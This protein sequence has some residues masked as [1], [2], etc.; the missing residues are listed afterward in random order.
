MLDLS[1]VNWSLGYS[2]GA[3][4]GYVSIVSVVGI[5]RFYVGLELDLSINSSFFRKLV[6]YCYRSSGALCVVFV[7]QV[8][9][10][11]F[12]VGCCLDRLMLFLSSSSVSLF[13][14][15]LVALEQYDRGVFG[16]V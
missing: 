6:G 7:L 11:H 3:V 8:G 12:R 9:G 15:G 14:L 5:G 13:Q 10:S 4:V 16:S 2:K 1:K